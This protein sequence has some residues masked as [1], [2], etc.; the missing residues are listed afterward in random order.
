MALLKYNQSLSGKNNPMA[1]MF[2]NAMLI[3]TN[4]H[5]NIG[6]KKRR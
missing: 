3:S 5:E 1:E 2:V 6:Y 4:R